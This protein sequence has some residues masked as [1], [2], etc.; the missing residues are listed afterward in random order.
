MVLAHQPQR[1]E[2]ARMFGATDVVTTSGRGAISE[3]LELTGGGRHAVL[4]WVG[5]EEVLNLSVSVARPGGI[6]G[7]VGTPHG[8]GHLPL[9]RMFSKNIGLRG[10]PAHHAYL[11]ELLNEILAGLLN[12][13]PILDLAVGLD[14]VAFGYAAMDQRRAM[15]GNDRP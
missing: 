11:P 8:S 9:Q 15:K 13:S 4:E 14:E 10:G 5:S 2:M 3:I 1:L 6:I 7:F 12:P